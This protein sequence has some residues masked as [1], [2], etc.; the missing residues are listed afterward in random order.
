[1]AVDHFVDLRWEPGERTELVRNGPLSESQLSLGRDPVL[2]G[3]RRAAVL[4]GVNLPTGK[5]TVDSSYPP[6]RGLGASGAGL[7][8]GLMIGNRLT[9]GKLAPERMLTEAIG[10]EGHPENAT[11]SLLGG[12]HWSV[13]DE[14]K[15]WVHLPLVLHKDLRF[16][17]VIPPYQLSTQRSREVLPTSVSLQR[18]V[19]QARRTP[20]LVEGLKKLN[21]ELIRIGVQ[22]ELHVAARL[23]L[24]TGAKLILDFADKAGA[25]ASTLSGAG[26]AL[27]VITRTGAVRELES[28]L[29]KRV[30][31]LW[32]DDGHVLNARVALKGA[33]F[34]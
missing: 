9:G 18:A 23:K 20:M 3:M 5:V 8:G 31:R 26:S 2:R 12:A 27:L 21:P 25:I 34:V 4:A 7:I 14:R 1:V 32:G 24:L 17:L 29:A 13:P 11:A 6:G 16:L 15:D 28:K 30:E 22:D 33:A 19:Q 10:L